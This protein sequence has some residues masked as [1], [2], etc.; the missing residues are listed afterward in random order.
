[1][2][3]EIR[4]PLNSILG[5]SSLL[6]RD[7]IGKEKRIKYLSLIESGGERL[8]R[9]INDIVDL[10]KI[11]S[12][13]L[14]LSYQPCQLNEVIDN[15]NVQF[16]S[17]FT[18]VKSNIV[19]KKGLSDAESLILIDEVR[20]IQIL[21]N[22]IE[23]S[24]KYANN[25]QITIGY[26][27]LNKMLTFYVSD[28]GIG[29]AASEHELIFGRFIRVENEFLSSTPGTGLG[30]SIV[31]ELTKLMK[32]KVWVESEVGKGSTF[33]FTIPYESAKHENV[34]SENTIVETPITGESK[35]IILVA[36]D[37]IINYLYLV[38]LFENYPFKLIRAANGE[39]AI[40]LV[41]TNSDISLVLMDMK[42]PKINGLEATIEIRKINQWIPII[43][44]TAYAFAEDKTKMLNA[45]CN[46]YL[47][48]PYNE[49]MLISIVEK[50]TKQ[51]NNS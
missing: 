50:Y 12:N 23:N 25:G 26:E 39:E 4:T 17:N 3:H 19:A 16:G 44:L 11:D 6:K 34:Q 32:G 21:S 24:I 41:K 22:L 51:D 33:Y 14:T 37:E 1:M 10:S 9:I 48:K 27:L 43:A 35:D 47:T 13:Q 30:L 7:N 38:A 18:G 36:E 15:L 49:K 45:G 46:D 40:K 2:S 8:L 5:F 28:E 29:I 42:M 20:L 31:S